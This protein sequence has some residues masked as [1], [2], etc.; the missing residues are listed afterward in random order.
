MPMPPLHEQFAPA[1]DKLAEPL[2]KASARYLLKQMVLG[3]L[4]E[5]LAE[6][7]LAVGAAKANASGDQLQKPTSSGIHRFTAELMGDS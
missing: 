2:G 4:Y 6:R 5:E 7:V 3:R 1:R